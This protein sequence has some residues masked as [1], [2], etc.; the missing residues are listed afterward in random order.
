MVRMEKNGSGLAAAGLGRPH[1]N[2]RKPGLKLRPVA[3]ILQDSNCYYAKALQAG[4]LG[5]DCPVASSQEM[6]PR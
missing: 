5:T 2:R 6:L 3:P 1:A 4:L